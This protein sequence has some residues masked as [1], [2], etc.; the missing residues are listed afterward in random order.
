MLKFS[1]AKLKQFIFQTGEAKEKVPKKVASHVTADGENQLPPSDKKKTVVSATDDAQVT[2]D[3]KK[4]SVDGVKPEKKKKDKK[5]KVK[6]ATNAPT[7]SGVNSQAKSEA[8]TKP[9]SA[10]TK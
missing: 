3:K 4:I 8:K 7:A 6:D 5:K 1:E 2:S 9:A 10:T